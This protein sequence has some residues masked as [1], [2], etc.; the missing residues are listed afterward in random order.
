MSQTQD[1]TISRDGDMRGLVSLTML[2]DPTSSAAEAY[3]S[4]RAS[5]KFADIQPSI[6]SVLIADTGPGAG[7]SAI[8]A[9]LAAALALAGDTVILIDANLR[10]PRLHDFFGVHS[11]PGLADWL[12]TENRSGSPSLQSTSI[13]GLRIL[14]SGSVAK[15]GRSGSTPSDYIGGQP[16]EALI[17]L[18]RGNADF[19]IFDAPPLSEFGDALAV[20]ARADAVLLLV[21][22]GRTKRAAAQRAKESLDRIGAHILGAVL[23]DSGGRFRIRG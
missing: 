14:S 23:T 9:N 3:R 12:D 4:L 2:A 15:L 19:L 22:S 10:N 5:V 21:H 8:A 13:E 7:H 18:L 11:E 17:D 20:A 1:R 16:F 6:H